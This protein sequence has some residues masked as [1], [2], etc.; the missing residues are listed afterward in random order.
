[1]SGLETA[2]K[3]EWPV[4][5]LF[6]VL[7][8]ATA[9]TGIFAGA[10][11]FATLVAFLGF[12]CAR[13]WHRMVGGP[14]YLLPVTATIVALGA[15]VACA[16]TASGS[17]W[18]VWF[19][20]F[21]S[22]AAAL[23]A[24]VSGASPLWNGAGTLY[25]GI[26]ALSLVLLRTQAPHGSVAVVVV[27]LAVW[28]ADSG[29]LAGGKLVG[30]PKFAPRLSP[31]KTWAGFVAGTVLSAAAVALFVEL[32]GGRWWEAAVLG[33]GLALAGHGGDL[34]ESWVKRRVGRKNSGGLIPGHGGIL[35]RLD[36]TLYAA[37]LA[38][39]LVFVFGF[40]PLCG[41]HP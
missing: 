17:L 37:P 8:A 26:P 35:D 22:M 9:L 14:R 34:F 38:A 29:A 36:S 18:P 6:G 28:V 33:L 32:H 2:G 3:L 12:A 10:Y 39:V 23:T 15:A 16:V 31:N 24:G 5:A 21:G 7:L 11:V 40:D 25:L 13:E 4:R 19:L 20:G 27:F 41:G 30:G 1:M